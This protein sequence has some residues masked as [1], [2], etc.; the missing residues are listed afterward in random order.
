MAPR[1]GDG[2]CKLAVTLDEIMSL[3]SASLVVLVCQ[4]SASGIVM[5]SFSNICLSD[6][7]HVSDTVLGS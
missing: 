3:Q 6:A 2:F 4:Y 5:Q 1:P 7:C